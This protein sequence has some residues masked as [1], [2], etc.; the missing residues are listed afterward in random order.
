MK[1][2]AAIGGGD[3]HWW[4]GG[5]AVIKLAGEA[6]HGRFSL[7][8]MLVPAGYADVP[9]HVHREADEAYYILE[10]E[11]TLEVG[12]ETRIGGPGAVLYVPKGTRHRFRASPVSPL[13]YVILYTP[14]GFEGYIR[15]SGM[16]ARA[17]TLPPPPNPSDPPPDFAALNRLMSERY[18]T[19]CVE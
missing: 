7:I 17:L 11:M 4:F 8:E 2:D 16:P 6:T 13:R 3:A 19:D 15:A 14:A 12:E 1:V 10:G 5:L 18:A 9:W